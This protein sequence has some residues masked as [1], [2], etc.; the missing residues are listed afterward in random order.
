MHQPP[1]TSSTQSSSILPLALGW[2]MVGFYI[3]FTLLNNS[4]SLMV[5]SPWVFIWLVGLMLVQ[6]L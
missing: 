3:L 2:G 4:N 1:P 5:K 6:V